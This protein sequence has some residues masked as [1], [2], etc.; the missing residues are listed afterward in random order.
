MHFLH[1]VNL[2][3]NPLTTIEDSYLFNLPALKYLDLGRT[4]VSIS[5]VENILMKT[6][7]LEK[8]N[9]QGNAISY[10]DKNVWKAYRWVETLILSENY[11][12]ELH[13][14]SFEGLLSLKHLDLSCNKIQ[15]IERR[16]F[17]SL[18]FLKSVN[19]GCNLLTEV[20]LGTFQA[21][22]GMHFL[23]VVNLDQNPLTTIE[24]SYLFNLPALKYLDL[25]RTQVSIS[26]VENILMKTLELEKLILPS[27]MACCLCQFKKDIETV[28]NTVKLHCRNECLTNPLSCVPEPSTE[29]PK[30]EF[31]KI[32]QA[33]KRNTSTELIITSETHNSDKH[34]LDILD[35]TNEQLDLNE[36]VDFISALNYVLRYFSGSNL[37]DVESALLP[38]IKLIFSSP[39]EDRSVDHLTNHLE[40]FS[41][42]AQKRTL[43]EIHFLENLINSEIEQKMDEVKDSK[44]AVMLMQPPLDIRGKRRFFLRKLERTRSQ[45]ISL[46]PTPS[47][48]QRLQR[49]KNV[50]KGSEGLRKRQQ[51]EAIR[52]RRENA[53][54]LVEG[55][56]QGE[57]GSTGTREQEELPVA[58]RPWH[59]VANSFH[60]EPPLTEE[61]S[62]RAASSLKRYMVDRPSAALLVKSLA[63]LEKG[64]IDT[65]KMR[66]KKTEAAEQS[67][68]SRVNYRLHRIDPHPVFRTSKSKVKTKVATEP[69]TDSRVK[70]HFNKIDLH[71]VFK[72]RKTKRR[73]HLRRKNSLNTQ[74]SVKRPP[75]LTLQSLID[76]PPREPSPSSGDPSSQDIPSPEAKALSISPAEDILEASLAAGNDLGKS[77]PASTTQGHPLAAGSPEIAPNSVVVTEKMQ[78]G[79]PNMGKDIPSIPTGTTYPLQS[80]PGDQLESQLNQQLRSLIPNN[81]VRKFISLVIHTLQTD[82][83]DPQ[84]QLSCAKL[85]SSTGLLMKLLSERQPVTAAKAEW[86]TDRREEENYISESPGRLSDA[87]MIESTEVR[88]ATRQ[89]TCPFLS[90]RKCH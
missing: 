6:L 74:S 32:L 26:T 15:F 48:R 27:H 71:P 80:S 31:L 56:V 76:S 4:Q 52:R 25:G 8:L 84:V 40:D 1:V 49:Q 62:A 81:D 58:Q 67:S 39:E 72:T 46:A 30:A 20:S 55:T 36:K 63:D 42:K 38:Y 18:P 33:R 60:P 45:Q 47:T 22:H 85:I 23:H 35:S 59:L 43:G 87:G 12:T 73:L 16:T 64:L 21:W 68:Y 14:D 7:E 41:V 53:R 90:L 77:P 5:T 44:K 37:E 17:E 50:I 61:H 2:D 34:T 24:D 19:L 10:I 9:L 79:N 28:C 82:C 29:N 51:R 83:A 54:P 57:L 66:T 13:K 88:T 78:W 11:L 75:L 89:E 65:M 86:D 69:N 70:Y 3:Q